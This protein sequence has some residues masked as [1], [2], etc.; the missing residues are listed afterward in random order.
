[1]HIPSIGYLSA[2]NRSPCVPPVRRVLDN[3]DNMHLRCVDC[4]GHHDSQHKV[5]KENWNQGCRD[6]C[7]KVISG[8]LR[9]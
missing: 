9:V 8:E 2:T 1:M 3:A 7:E 5:E 6:I 4:D